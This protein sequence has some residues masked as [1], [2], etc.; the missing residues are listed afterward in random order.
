MS[1]GLHMAEHPHAK[2]IFLWPD[3]HWCFRAAA[4]ADSSQ[5]DGHREI[6]YQSEEWCSRF[7]DEFTFKYVSTA[8]A[9]LP[10]LALRRDEG[11]SSD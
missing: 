1:Q 10:R 7:I 9:R 6:E 2:D 4:G 3:G 8:A 11:K 5:D